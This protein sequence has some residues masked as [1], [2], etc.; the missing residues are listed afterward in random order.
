MVPNGKTVSFAE[1][2]YNNSYQ[3]SLQMAP[4]EVLYGRK[5]RTLLNWSETGDG[6]IFGPEVLHRAEEKVQLVPKI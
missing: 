2:S 4:F 5:C 6:L 1:F 3:S